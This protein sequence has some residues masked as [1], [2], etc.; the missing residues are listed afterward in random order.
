[1]TARAPSCTR[2]KTLRLRSSLLR[3]PETGSTRTRSAAGTEHER[4]SWMH[5]WQRQAERKGEAKGPLALICRVLRMRRLRKTPSLLSLCCGA[6][7]AGQTQT[8]EMTG[9][10]FLI[11]MK[12][13]GTLSQT[14]LHMIHLQ[15]V[16]LEETGA[17]EQMMREVEMAGGTFLPDFEVPKLYIMAS[18]LRR[19]PASIYLLADDRGERLGEG[20]SPEMT[21]TTKKGQSLLPRGVEV[22]RQN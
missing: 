20:S 15:G 7:R 11:E 16:I 6:D 3:T 18:P 13:T 1:M 10:I 17:G 5:R 19:G 14:S 12:V 9:G 21:E 8:M 4:S 2:E 22:T